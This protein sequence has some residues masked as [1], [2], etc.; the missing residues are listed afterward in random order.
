MCD[1]VTFDLDGTLID[2]KKAMEESLRYALSKVDGLPELD[3]KINIP[4]GPPLNKI[5]EQFLGVGNSQVIELVKREFIYHYDNITW[6]SIGVFNGIFDL[7]STLDSRGVTLALITNKRQTPTLKILKKFGWTETFAKVYCLD[8]YAGCNGKSELL[9]G[10]VSANPGSHTY[11]GDTLE[12]LSAAQMCGV[13]FVGASWGYGGVR[14][15]SD[16][17]ASSPSDLKDKL[18]AEKA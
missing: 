14:F 1:F 15:K 16:C 11:V 10:Y 9:E 8:Q 4:I 18:V 7:I 12:D 17:M 5:L 13:K 3:A 6:N 2:S